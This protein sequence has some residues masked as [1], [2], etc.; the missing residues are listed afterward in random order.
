MFVEC[1]PGLLVELISIVVFRIGGGNVLGPASEMIAC[2]S[3]D[4]VSKQKGFKNGYFVIWLCLT[5]RPL[6]DIVYILT[7]LR[8]GGL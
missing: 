8:E 4:M 5:H 6:L 1:L 7:L 3:D 2:D